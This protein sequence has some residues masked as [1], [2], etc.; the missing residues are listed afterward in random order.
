MANNSEWLAGY[1]DS[2]HPTLYS[3]DNYPIHSNAAGGDPSKN[4][5][6]PG[7]YTV[8]GPTPRLRDSFR[9]SS[10]PESTL[11]TR[12]RA[13]DNTSE[14]ES[15]GKRQRL[16]R[17]M[18]EESER[19]RNDSLA[20]TSAASAR[21]LIPNQTTPHVGFAC[22]ETS[23]A[24]Q[25]IVPAVRPSIS[26]MLDDHAESSKDNAHITAWIDDVNSC[27]NRPPATSV[28]VN[29]AD[30][31]V[32]ASS[33]SLHMQPGDF[34]AAKS[35]WGRED[36]PD[37]ELAPVNVGA[38]KEQMDSPSLQDT[39]TTR[40][41]QLDAQKTEATLTDSDDDMLSISSYESMPEE[42]AADSPAAGDSTSKLP[43][44]VPIGQLS[45][46][47]ESTDTI[48]IGDRESSS[49]S[50]SGSPPSVSRIE[51]GKQRSTKSP[52][53]SGDSSESEWSTLDEECDEC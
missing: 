30:G 37:D 12:I 26:L 14:S 33:A 50:A 4:E 10:P 9:S 35:G 34:N 23:L 22:E 51:K 24:P 21:P 31:I 3:K 32:E 49:P 36:K 7:T 38:Q 1:G 5:P 16:E 42:D 41:G 47:S 40:D 19:G 15:P 20:T 27:Y 46:A 53:Q 11:G 18:G 25:K 48:R 2:F 39:S 6:L 8:R 52:G 29:R 13:D 28:S 44:R 45:G 17:Y 43:G